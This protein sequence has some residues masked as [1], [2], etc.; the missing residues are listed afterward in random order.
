MRIAII[1]GAGAMGG[2]FLFASRVSQESGVG[3]GLVGPLLAITEGTPGPE[4]VRPNRNV[5]DD[6]ISPGE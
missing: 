3:S 6:P 2:L 4:F 1:G 5:E